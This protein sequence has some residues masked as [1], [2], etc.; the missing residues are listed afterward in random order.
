MGIK[1][2]SCRGHYNGMIKLKKQGETE[3]KA[4][5]S[6]GRSTEPDLGGESS[7]SGEVSA[8]SEGSG[9]SAKM[10]Y[11]ASDGGV[12]TAWL[13]GLRALLQAALLSMWGTGGSKWSGSAR[14]RELRSQ[15]DIG[16]IPALPCTSCWLYCLEP[17]CFHQRT[18]DDTALLTV[19]LWERG[20]NNIPEN[21]IL[22]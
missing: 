15:I 22:L 14:S 4:L 17:Q 1:G 10:C 12:M 9:G 19:R 5:E 21:K 16:P 18:E 11:P 3:L 8:Q 2:G 7:A 6:W 13:P 20:W